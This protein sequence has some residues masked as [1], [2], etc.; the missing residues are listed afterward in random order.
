MVHH[1][2]GGTKRFTVMYHC[3]ALYVGSDFQDT[4]LGVNIFT[5]SCFVVIFVRVDP[6]LNSPRTD[7]ILFRFAR[8]QVRHGFAVA[9]RMLFL[10][11]VLYLS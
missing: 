2:T 3:L 10:L 8:R 6:V 7:A 1:I 4:I 5:G 9:G 11:A